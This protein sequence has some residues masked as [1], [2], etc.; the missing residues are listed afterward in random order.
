[1]LTKDSDLKTCYQQARELYP[2]EH[3]TK[4]QLGRYCF[5]VKTNNPGLKTKLDRYFKE[6]MA[7]A[8][9]TPYLEIIAIECEPPSIDRE[10]LT[11]KQPD[12]GKTK[13]KEEY[14]NI[15]ST[16]LVRKRLTDMVFIF[17]SDFHLAMGP[18]EA[19]DNQIVNF[20]N[21]RFLELRLNL[22]AQ[23]GHAAAVLHN[24]KAMMFAGFSGAGKSTLSLQVMN[25]GT[26]FISN[27]RVLV[28][29]E[30]G[31][32]V[33][34]GIP[35]HP[36]INPGT[37]VHNEKLHCLVPEDKRNDYLAMG[38][39]LWDLEDKYDGFIDQCY[40]EN[41][42]KLFNKANFLILLNWKRNDDPI[43]MKEIDI[44]QRRELLPAFMKETGMFYLPNEEGKKVTRTEEDYLKVLSKIR[45]FEF[46]GGVDFE[47]GAQFCYELLNE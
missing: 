42:F 13:I 32:V 41:K 2:T 4:L 7:E 31:E 43:V 15:G 1:M 27:D 5:S 35:K 38:D 25:L 21:N 19:N 10:Q 36:R 22:G 23:L 30:E 8:D 20:I 11:V 45:V 40:G 18:C 46:S 3:E 6:F 39:D 33:V 17:G 12:P 26:T 28:T 47:K 37:I 9:A 14:F 34:E 44:S 29:E 16:R 24:E